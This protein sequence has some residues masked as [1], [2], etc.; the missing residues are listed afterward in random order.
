MRFYLTC[1]AIFF[2][3]I[4][5]AQVKGSVIDAAIPAINPMNPNGDGFITSNG[6]AFTGPLDETQFE[7]P[8]IPISQFQTE[9]GNDNQYAPGCEF[10]ELVN[11]PTQGADAGYFYYKDADGIPDNG[12]EVIIFRFRLSKYS[13]SSTAF[14]ILIDSDYKFGSSGPEAD[15][16]SVSGNPGFELEIGC[17]NSTGGAG[18][19]WVFDVNGTAAATVVKFHHSINSHYQV[20]YAFNNDAGCSN[21][22]V[23]VDMYIPFSDLGILSTTQV[24]MAVAVNEDI[25]T[26]LGGGA[27]D[28]GGVNGN[29]IT[30]DDDQF[31]A[32]ILNY[33]P[34]AIGNNT[35]KAP[36]AA[37]AVIALQENTNTTAILHTVSATDPNSDV[38]S[39][40]ITQGN[41]Q[42]AFAINGV[43]GEITINNPAALDIETNRSFTLLVKVSDSKLFDNAVIAVNLTDINEF[44]P[45]IAGASVTI[46][47][48]SPIATVVYSVAASDQDVSA[49][50]SYSIT[51]GNTAS[52]FSINNSGKILVNG[53]LNFETSVPYNLGIQVSDGINVAQAIVSVT[54]TNVNEAPTA[55]DATVSLDE[56]VANATPVHLMQS[57]DP[58]AG[59]TFTYSIIGGNS[60]VAFAINT[61]TGRISV[62]NSSSLNFENT[63]SFT[64]TVRVS[65]GTLHDD[66]VIRVDINDVNEAPFVSNASVPLNENAPEGTVVHL[67]SATDPDAGAVL[68]YTITGGN[69]ATAFKIN[70]LTGEIAVND[71]GPLDFETSPLFT[72]TVR[73]DDGAL[74]NQAIVSVNVADI[75]DAPVVR[76]AD[77]SL[78]ENSV[79]GTI[80]YTVVASDQDSPSA[81]LAYSIS[82]GN[83]ESVFA[84]DAQGVI[85]VNNLSKLDFETT[86]AFPLT[87][88]VSDGFL[89]SDGLITIRLQN[90]NEAPTALSATVLIDEKLPKGTVVYQVLASDPDEGDQLTFSIAGGNNES[91]FAIQAASGEIIINDAGKVSFDINPVFEISIN[92]VDQNNLSASAL[93]RLELNNVPENSEITPLKGFSPDGDGINDY[94]LINGIQA[95]P[96]NEVKV[97]NRW[98]NLVF[99]TSN[100]DNERLAWRG[101]SGGGFVIGSRDVVDNTYY[102]IINI[103]R[104]APITGYLIVKK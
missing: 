31:V 93:V 16:N 86:K 34:I 103:K 14:S 70:N 40:S 18:G 20:S 44:T 98:G 69:T 30:N 63:P 97:F 47:E 85:R 71:A 80:V 42:N 6:L 26:S 22:P 79:N 100:Y 59:T 56:N 74:F 55:A 77:V 10:Y 60:G 45:I 89:S 99:E 5:F 94:W 21:V 54:V 83:V 58:D 2:T 73:V 82:G 104:L 24:R 76:D 43:T 88:D 53:A 32:A 62:S 38:L 48:N 27:S 3:G 35:N 11:D 33:S 4:L 57:T 95:F 8:L 78:M 49:V 1:I 90:V 52:A 7:L 61:G 91:A 29:V 64:L 75:N 67:V 46:S 36:V 37:D 50:L 66:A 84:I 51:S 23:F 92:A 101:E 17:F 96:D 15:P 9:S 65:D 72:L 102:Y 87:I 39:Y 12:D 81:V 41:T 68:T 19:V 25:A 28:V 13:P